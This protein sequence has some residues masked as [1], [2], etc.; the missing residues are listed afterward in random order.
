ML[1]PLLSRH[2]GLGRGF[3][4]HSW[5]IAFD[6]NA[7]PRP[8]RVHPGLVKHF[9][10]WRFTWGGDFKRNVDPMHFQYASGY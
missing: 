7:N 2:D 10:R 6:I 1:T 4:V 9:K 3:T 5:G 8:V